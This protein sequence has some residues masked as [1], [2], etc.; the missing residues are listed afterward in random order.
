MSRGVVESDRADRQVIELEQLLKRQ[1]AAARVDD[2][3]TVEQLAEECTNRAATAGVMADADKQRLQHLHRQ[4]ECILA[5][6]L[7]ATEQQLANVKK[8]KKIFVAYRP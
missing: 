6:K 3:S 7:A 1:I 5:D 2:F 4:L 8:S